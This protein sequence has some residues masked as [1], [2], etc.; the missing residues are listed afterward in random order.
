FISHYLISQSAFYLT[1]EKANHTIKFFNR[2]SL[3][4]DYAD[5]FDTRSIKQ[6][7]FMRNSSG[8][9]TWLGTWGSNGP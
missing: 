3:D 8:A 2:R 9:T 5:D 4:E 1:C 7:A 6:I